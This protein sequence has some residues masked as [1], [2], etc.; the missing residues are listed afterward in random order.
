MA[1][2]VSTD[3]VARAPELSAGDG[4]DSV[5]D[6]LDAVV[7]LVVTVLATGLAA[8][9]AAGVVLPG[10]RRDADRHGAVVVQVGGQQLLV[11]LLAR[12]EASRGGVAAGG[13]NESNRETRQ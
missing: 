12:V 3:A 6:Q 11:L 10:G 5:S 1:A 9:D 8:Q 2:V 13:G 7:E 4:L